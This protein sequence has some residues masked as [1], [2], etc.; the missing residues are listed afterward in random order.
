MTEEEINALIA[1]RDALRKEV[2]Q[3]KAMEQQLHDMETRLTEAFTAG[4]KLP[5]NDAPNDP[6]EGLLNKI[7]TGGQK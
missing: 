5:E 6:L 2:E 3:H 1:E 4:S 7:F